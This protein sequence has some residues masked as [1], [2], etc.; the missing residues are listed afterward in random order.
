[1]ISWKILRTS[2]C[3]STDTPTQYAV[4][5]THPHHDL[6]PTGCEYL[7]LIEVHAVID[8]QLPGATINI[9][10]LILIVNSDVTFNLPQASPN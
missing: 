6:P 10:N 5:T 7:S 4:R 3:V 8:G 2:Y 1:M 9:E